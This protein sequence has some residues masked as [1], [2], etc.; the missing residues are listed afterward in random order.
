MQLLG[1]VR[2]RS[3]IFVVTFRFLQSF[4]KGSLLALCISTNSF[5]FR[6]IWLGDG[7]SCDVESHPALP[8]LFLSFEVGADV[9]DI[10]I[11]HQSAHFFIEF[12]PQLAL[13]THQFTY[14]FVFLLQSLTKVVK[15]PL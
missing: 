11:S 7:L 3:I 14:Y 5:F 13:L 6:G 15:F 1:F 9:V 10:A 2:P 12:A 8:F 4:E